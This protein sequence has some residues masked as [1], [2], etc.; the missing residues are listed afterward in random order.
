MDLTDAAVIKYL[1]YQVNDDGTTT[2]LVNAEA[3]AET[4]AISGIV[5]YDWTSGDTATTG[6]HLSE[7]EIEFT[8][9]HKE[10]FPTRGYIE[11]DIESDLDNEW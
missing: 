2:E 9:G 5:R 3:Y 7:F 4:P 10:T 11:I 8:D 6:S 1:M